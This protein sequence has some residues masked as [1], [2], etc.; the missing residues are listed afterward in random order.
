MDRENKTLNNTC[1]KIYLKLAIKLAADHLE[2]E[3]GRGR[4]VGTM[5]NGLF[6]TGIVAC[7]T[8][9]WPCKCRWG[10]FYHGDLDSC[11]KRWYIDYG[12]YFDEEE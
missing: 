11:L 1:S 3:R 10:V 6:E 7:N 5:Q 4:R 9:G 8:L 2:Y 12:N